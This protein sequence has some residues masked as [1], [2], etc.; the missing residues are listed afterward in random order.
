ME[1]NTQN[2]S[3]MMNGIPPV[4]QPEKKIGPI[5]AILIIV[6]VLIIAGLYFFGQKL[7]TSYNTTSDQ[8]LT[9]AVQTPPASQVSY[10]QRSVANV[11][12]IKALENDIDAQLQEVD[13]SS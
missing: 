3:G 5:V 12:D 10:D 11:S 9:P 8:T 2:S 7:N 13:Y 6:L 1:Y 4:S